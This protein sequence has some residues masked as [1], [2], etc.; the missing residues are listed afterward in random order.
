MTFYL[1]QT[2]ACNYLPGQYATTVFL[3]PKTPKSTSLYTALSTHG[4]RRSGKE[5][6]KPHCRSCDACIPVR[7][8]VARFRPT[9][10]QRRA[11]GKNQDLTIKTR[12]AAFDPDHY[13]LFRKYVEQR[14]AGAGMDETSPRQYIDFLTSPWSETVFYEMRA[15]EKLLAVAVADVLTDALSAVYTF[16]DPESPA[17]SLGRFAILFEIEQAISLGFQWLY[18]GYWI[19]GCQ[20][21][22]YKNEYQPLEY[23][24]GQRW[25]ALSG[26]AG[27]GEER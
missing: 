11:W 1:A 23:Y 4:F 20:K 2:T 6:Y 16:F 21:M 27:H 26:C 5:I 17:R 18:L 19:E 12:A 7:L 3:D 8:P 22:R 24:R 10:N 14:H 15:G 13:A 9:R 25:Q